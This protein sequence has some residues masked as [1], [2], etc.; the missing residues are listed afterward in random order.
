MSG[1]FSEGYKEAFKEIFPELV[2]E[3]TEDGLNDPEISDG[4]QHLQRVMNYNVPKGKC[5]RG[6]M[7][8][9]SLLHL[10][11]DRE[12][13]KEEE[14]KGLVLGWCVEWLQAFFLVADDIMDQSKTRRGQPCWYLNEGVGLVAINDSF[15]LEGTIYNLLKK[16]FRSDTYYVDILEL[17][18]QVTYQT[19]M[20]QTLDLLTS[21]DD[22]VDFSRFS[23]KRYN[24]IVKYKTAFYSFYLP[25]ALAMYMVGIK[26]EK[27]H[28]AARAI[29]LEM[30]EF[31]QIQDDFLDC[32]GDPAV[33]G[34]VGTDIEEN[35]CSWLVVQALAKVSPQQ[36]QI[37]QDNYARKE[38]PECAERVKALYR[39]LSLEQQYRD[40]E[41]SSYKRLVDMID[42][43]ATEA[44]LPTQLFMEF[45]GRIYKRKN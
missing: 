35:K 23:I 17:F 11:K 34:K 36:K 5:N 2:K 1:S 19:E 31:F 45:A 18:H 38:P 22:N 3:L 13:S 24:S 27:S 9:S 21:P 4:V 29:L 25:V 15:C 16:Y 28:A 33:T 39:D 6:L 40:Y 30:G 8:I 42:K 14:R 12:L 41:E 7:V 43:Q 26:D 20:G 10:T 44:G 37:L 32:F